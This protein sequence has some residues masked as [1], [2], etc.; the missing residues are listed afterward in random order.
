[1]TLHWGVLGTGSIA[2]QFARDLVHLPAARIVAVGSRTQES[3]DRFADAHDIEVRHASYADLVLEEQVDAVYVATPHPVHRECALLA[4][5]AGKPVL[6]E[7][8]FAL[9]AIEAQEIVRAA[10]DAGTFCMEAMWT[11]FLPY[12]V[13]IR[14]LIA[15]GRLG[16]LRSVRADFGELFPVD[17]THRAYAPELGGGALLDLGVYPVSFAMMLLGPPTDI[18]ALHHEAPTG[19]DGQTVVVMRH[20]N[21]ALSQSSC[22]FEAK[23]S[24][25]A[26]IHGALGRIEVDGDFYAH[27]AFRIITSDGD[28]EVVDIPHVGRGLRHQAAEVARCLA[29]GLTESPVLTL[30]DTL[31]VMETMD[32]VR[33]QI[34]LVYPGEVAASD[35]TLR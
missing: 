1:M 33:R 35:T 20:E 32:E 8:P 18:K 23:A 2:A 6:V 31:A 7:K 17:A 16:E 5:D 10:R 21:G 22:S 11:R 30:D 9:N 15:A 12:V 19:V 13:A 34:G 28:V 29:A 24:N 25:T 3:A 4:I 27:S 14:E 26:S